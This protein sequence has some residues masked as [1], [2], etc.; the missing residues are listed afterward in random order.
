A[1][2]NLDGV[3][4]QPGI[5][6]RVFA[7]IAEQ[8]IVVDMIVQNVGCAGRAAIGFTVL[9]NDLPATLA[10]L[11]ALAAELGAQVNHEE[12]VSKVAIVGNGMGTDTGGA[13]RMF[14]ALAAEEINV[15]MIAT[16]DIKI[17]VL[18]EKTDGHRALRAVHQAF[19]LH[20][21]RRGAGLVGPAEPTS[22]RPRTPAILE[23]PSN[24]DL[25]QRAGQLASM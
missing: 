12:D 13:E 20:Q 10:V 11:R 6:H 16:G 5:S 17:S 24:R 2:V 14:A 7:A 8:N 25:A 18:V 21:P 23:E 22:F 3:P 1:R 9:R 15:K 4:D 19:G